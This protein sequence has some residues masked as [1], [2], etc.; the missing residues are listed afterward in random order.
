MKPTKIRISIIGDK[1]EEIIYRDRTL[2]SP[3]EG[4]DEMVEDMLDSLA[5]AK[6][7]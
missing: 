6:N 5:K 7:F 2:N 1:G 3:V 4:L